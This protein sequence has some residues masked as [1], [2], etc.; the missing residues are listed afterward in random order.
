M[1]QS[2]PTTRVNEPDLRPTVDALRHSW[3][4]GV[5]A[6][7]PLVVRSLEVVGLHVQILAMGTALLDRLW[8]AISHHPEPD[9]DPDLVLHLWDL[10]S[11]GTPQPDLPPEMFARD[12]GRLFDT[13]ITEGARVRYDPASRALTAWDIETKSAWCCAVT[14]SEIAWWEQAAPFRSLFAWWLEHHGRQMIHGAAVGEVEGAVILGG[15]GGSGKSTTALTAHLAGI[16]Y[17]GDDYCGLSHQ[18]GPS[19]HSLYGTAKLRLTDHDERGPLAGHL[20]RPA[21][22]PDEKA[23]A[24]VTAVPDARII[25]SAPVRA[26]LAVRI[27]TT[28]MT[29]IF[30]ATPA[31]VLAAIAPSSIL[32]IHGTGADSFAGLARLVREVPVGLLELG[33]DRSEIVEVL[34]HAASTGLVS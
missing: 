31:Q 2:G 4:E 30:P 11:T 33:A 5:R 1:A 17:L 26:V 27:G 15:P 25:E 18:H 6:G 22:R 19:V 8:P 20:L 9:G 16:G 23:V 12:D 34:N 32:Q 7:R 28:R 29:R 10:A 21:P 13:V 14:P 3:D 24:L